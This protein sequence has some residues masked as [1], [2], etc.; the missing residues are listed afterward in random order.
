MTG[1]GNFKYLWLKFGDWLLFDYWPA[2]AKPLRRRQ[3]LD[4]WIFDALLQEIYFDDP[5]LVMLI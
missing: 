5:L 1:Q 4:Y 3:V 2:C